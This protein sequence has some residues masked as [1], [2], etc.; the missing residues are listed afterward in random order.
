MEHQRQLDDYLQRQEQ[1]RRNYS[2]SDEQ[3]IDCL[4]ECYRILNISPTATD[5]EV[6]MAYQRKADEFQPDKIQAAGL[7]EAFI[8]FAQEQFQKISHAY[9][10]ICNA[11]N[12]T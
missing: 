4:D 2:I 12:I 6:N 9:E 10:T 1:K 7:S 5:E 3:D 8:T 11:R